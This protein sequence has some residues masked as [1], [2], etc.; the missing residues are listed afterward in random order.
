VNSCYKRKAY[1]KSDI[2]KELKW[3][4]VR[5]DITEHESFKSTG[6]DLNVEQI[7]KKFTRLYT[8]VKVK[9]SIEGEGSNLSGLPE[10]APLPE[11]VL[12][13]MIKEVYE[14]SEGVEKKKVVKDQRN[15]Q[16]LAHEERLVSTK[17]DSK[18]LITA[19]DG[20]PTTLNSS[21]EL[22]TG[23][24][25]S[26]STTTTNTTNSKPVDKPGPVSAL[27][28]FLLLKKEI[29]LAKIAKSTSYGSVSKEDF[30]GEPS[31]Y[32]ECLV[33]DLK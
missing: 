6:V 4:L 11:S 30:K 18:F 14:K 3:K 12:I 7:K 1:I 33:Y 13:K 25:S 8:A 24:S 9:Y 5:D 26:N 22:S 17:K 28:K 31:Q 20:S 29:E 27:D 15:K 32:Y 2:S 10:D 16:M 19:C 21:S 23:M